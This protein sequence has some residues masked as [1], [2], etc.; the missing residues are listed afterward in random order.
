VRPIALCEVVECTLDPR[1]RPAGAP[2]GEHSR[3]WSIVASRFATTSCVSADAA[4]DNALAF[5]YARLRASRRFGRNDVSAWVPEQKALHAGRCRVGE[6]CVGCGGPDLSASHDRTR[7]A[8][9]A[10]QIGS[11]RRPRSGCPEM[12]ARRSKRPP[13][14]G[15]PPN[16]RQTLKRPP[17]GTAPQ[18]ARVA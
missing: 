14:R 16:R 4:A 3:Q 7:C 17:W 9:A 6:P 8:R 12:G 5:A 2:E 11:A 15:I 13:A 10:V 18:N 1:N